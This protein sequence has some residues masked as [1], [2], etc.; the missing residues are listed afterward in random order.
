MCVY[1]EHPLAGGDIQYQAPNSWS[2]RYLYR[3]LPK[4][5]LLIGKDILKF[6]SIESG[7]FPNEWKVA[8]VAPIL[9]KG[10]PTDKKNYR[11]ISCL[12]TASKVMDNCEQLTRFLEVHGLLPEN[13]H[14]FRQKRSTMTA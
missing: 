7:I 14:G 2:I 13:Q 9:K 12:V 5:C 1:D 8:I 10:D 3:S 6:P 11:P 4:G